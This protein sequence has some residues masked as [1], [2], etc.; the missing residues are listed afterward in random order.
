MTRLEF[1]SVAQSGRRERNGSRK[2][3]GFF[4]FSDGVRIAEIFHGGFF[5]DLRRISMKMTKNVKRIGLAGDAVFPVK[6]RAP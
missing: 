2:R 1:L 4:R 3:N 5:P 6:K